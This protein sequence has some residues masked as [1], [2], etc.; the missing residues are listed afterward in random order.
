MLKK[1][2]HGEYRIGV[3]CDKTASG[4]NHDSNDDTMISVSGSN[5]THESC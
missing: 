2:K 1:T 5:K 4:C 3:K